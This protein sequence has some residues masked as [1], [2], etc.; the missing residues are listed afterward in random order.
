MTSDFKSTEL[1]LFDMA[2]NDANGGWAVSFTTY[3]SN[4]DLSPS[5][6]FETLAATPEIVVTTPD[7]D[8]TCLPST[9]A[10]ADQLR[11]FLRACRGI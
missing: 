10:D 3:G 1:H 11:A 8:L 5:E 9:G 7:G 6:W 2:A 4:S